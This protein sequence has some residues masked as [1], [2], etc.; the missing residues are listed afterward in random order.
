MA[1]YGPPAAGGKAGLVNVPATDI[2]VNGNGFDIPGSPADFDGAQA[3]TGGF[4]GTGFQDV[5]IYDASGTFAGEGV[6]LAREGDG[7][8]LQ[9]VSGSNCGIFSG[10]LADFNGDNPLQVVNAYASVTAMA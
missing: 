5:L 4:F 6:V 7:S 3:I 10:G 8:A 9:P 2:G 1:G